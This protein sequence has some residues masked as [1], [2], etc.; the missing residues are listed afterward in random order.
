LVVSVLSILIATPVTVWIVH[1]R[2]TNNTLHAS[3][4]DN[5]KWA[6]LVPGEHLIL[7]IDATDFSNPVTTNND[8][9]AMKKLSPTEFEA[10]RMGSGTITY[11][12]MNCDGSA[13][14]CSFGIYFWVVRP[15]E[16]INAPNG[17]QTINH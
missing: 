6:F 9:G 8:E 14:K 7:D 4:I 5:G 10:E 16:P 1:Q 2:S 3:L 15:N 12:S 11:R 13:D 17:I